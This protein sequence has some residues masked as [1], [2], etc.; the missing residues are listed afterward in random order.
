[1][2][3]IIVVGWPSSGKTTISR[4]IADFFQSK[5]KT[6]EIVS[7]EDLL[8]FHGRNVLYR[9]SRLEKD[10]RGS[11]KGEVMR[12]L[13]PNTLTILDSPNYIKG[14]RYELYCLSKEH[15][16]THCIVEMVIDKETVKTRNSQKDQ[17]S[18]YDGDV[19]EQ[20]L[21][22]YE[23]PDSR[24]RW[25]SPLVPVINDVIDFEALSAVLYDRKPPPPNLSTQSQA[26]SDSNY[27]TLVDSTTREVVSRILKIQEGGPLTNILIPGCSVQISLST[28]RI[29]TSIELNKM[30][31]QFITY[32]KSHPIRERSEEI[33]S[34]FMTFLSS[35]M[36]E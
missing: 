30:R 17:N 14:Y 15:K 27:L 28:P 18:Q 10:V 23:A 35:N 26:V 12:K 22:R 24:N 21:A 36:Q 13:N 33:T 2:P 16:T 31:R 20:L 9:D 5:E 19:L 29:L 4:K 3:L 8:S 34:N 25:D 11:L 6:V 7:D 1:M 32:T